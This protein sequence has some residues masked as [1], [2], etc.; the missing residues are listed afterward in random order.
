MSLVEA[1][2]INSVS[3]KSKTLRKLFAPY[4]KSIE[5]DGYELQVIT[6]LINLVYKRNE[7]NDLTSIKAAKEVLK[8]TELLAKCISEVKWYHT[9]NLKYPEIRVSHQRLIAEV[10]DKDIPAITSA[11]LPKKYGWSHNSAEINH[12][13]LFLTS[14][15]WQ[16]KVSSLATMLVEMQ[17]VWVDALRTLGLTKKSVMTLADQI[18][19]FIPL[20]DFPDVVSE[21]TSQLMMPFDKGYLSVSPVVSHVMQ[22]EIQQ[23]AQVKSVNWGTVEHARPTNIGDLASALG[24]KVRVLKYFPATS[25]HGTIREYLATDS[26]ERLFKHKVLFRKSFKAAL[27]ILAGECTYNTL[28]QKRLG[29]IAAIRQLRATLLHWLDKLV[30]LDITDRLDALPEPIKSLYANIDQDKT[31]LVNALNFQLNEQLAKQRTLRSFAYHPKLMLTLKSQFAYVL[32]SIGIP[33]ET[34][35][36]SQIVYVYCKNMRVF[37]AEGMPNP[38]L[39]GIP[40]L[41][42][43]A[44][45]AHKFQRK[46]QSSIDHSIE[47]IGSAFFLHSYKLHTGKLLPEPNQLKTTHG[48]TAVKR[49]GILEMPKCDMTVDLVFRLFVPDERSLTKLTDN[50]LKAA[51]PT[52]FAGGTMHPPSLY[53]S[54]EWCKVFT[55]PSELFRQLGLLSSKGCWLYPSKHKVKTFE[56]LLELLEASPN[57]R[58]AGVGFASLEQPTNRKGALA[59]QHCFVEPVLGSLECVNA[60]EMRMA[61]IRK[62]FH[63]AFWV[64]KVEKLS[65]LMKKAKFD[66]T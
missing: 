23:L 60:I 25:R 1:F 22:V 33:D 47:C 12:A 64:M 41:T 38:Y 59:P 39:Q 50:I 14:F 24:G 4:A 5:V 2:A 19:D 30:E 49:P 32:K 61:G 34:L 42:A 40:S 66:Y 27:S 20:T 56:N 15:K 11:S 6:V 31:Q 26:N 54:V 17:P 35:V 10:V 48:I 8:N 46:L 44:G 65:M 16:G 58:P 45:V 21:F 51:F 36:D 29:R 62:F 13:K 9:H 37:D 53:E 43:L 55:S 18:R 63:N 52:S 7:V 57:Q 3:E 28:R